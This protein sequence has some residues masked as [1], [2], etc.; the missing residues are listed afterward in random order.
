[1]NVGSLLFVS[2]DDP[3]TLQG[4]AYV[5]TGKW[6]LWTQLQQLSPLEKHSHS[7]FGKVLDVDTLSLSSAVVGCPLCNDTRFAGQIYVYS[8]NPTESG[9]TALTHTW[10]Q[11]QVLVADVHS[12]SE[13]PDKV[14]F[15]LG[16]KVKVH[17][18]VIL[19]MAQM[20]PHL[21]VM[22]FAKSSATGV[23]SHQQSLRLDESVTDFSVY[24]DTI[25]LSSTGESVSGFSEAGAVHVYYPNTNAY[26]IKAT[27]QIREGGRFAEAVGSEDGSTI[28]LDSTLTPRQSTRKTNVGDHN[29]V[30]MLVNPSPKSTHWSQYQTL[31]APT[32]ANA[33]NFGSDVSLQKNNLVV[34]EQGTSSV[35]LF[36]RTGALGTKWSQAQILKPS[37]DDVDFFSRNFIHGTTLVIAGIIGTQTHLE[38]FTSSM[39]WGCLII[40]VMD[41]FGDGW[42]SSQLE[43][44]TPIAGSYDYFAPYCN[45]PNPFTFRYCPTNPEDEGSYKFSVPNGILSKYHWEIVY[46]VEVE[47]TNELYRGTSDSIMTFYFNSTDL[48]FSYISGSNLLPFKDSCT[49]CPET[50]PFDT[51]AYLEVKMT[52][53]N[54]YAWFDDSYKGTSYSISD[55]EGRR[56]LVAG[57]SCDP[58]S[59]GNLTEYSCFHVLVDGLYTF[60]LS[61]DINDPT[62]SGA[63][64]WSFCNKTGTDSVHMYFKIS[65]GKCISVAS[66]S[67]KPFCNPR[68][69]TLATLQLT[70]DV[71]NTDFISEVANFAA[72]DRAAFSVSLASLV[73][74]VDARDIIFT[75]V[76]SSSRDVNI[77][78]VSVK[79]LVNTAKAGYDAL[80][81]TSMNSMT[82]SAMSMLREGIAGSGT[83][84]GVL[85]TASTYN[86]TFFHDITAVSLVTLSTNDV[87]DVIYPSELYTYATELN[88]DGNSFIREI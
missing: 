56:Q 25:V 19:G 38:T 67:L 42:D 73:D 70:V 59:Q 21:S 3:E 39:D 50:S 78:T 69:N 64:S 44:Q 30:H 52:S 82:S 49:V 13:S 53:T 80:D 88:S 20:Y 32:I 23:W 6:D 76:T 35:Y 14:A 86:S 33:N 43:I 75:S 72:A 54:G 1:M 62:G 24:D 47:K 17:G 68:L 51:W 27:E 87:I 81:L 31:H 29:D 8:P 57:T 63:M 85:K 55:S 2:A 77:T 71:S 37:A 66:Y 16:S 79:L 40:E 65:G 83:F 34:G 15:F 10:S 48:S 18:N 61:E 11:T 58:S 9:G 46:Q 12:F 84:F 4:N 7:D 45:Y 28:Q 36:R 5:F 26:F 41:K 60:R 74:F 22:A